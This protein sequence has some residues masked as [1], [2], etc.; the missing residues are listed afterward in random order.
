MHPPLAS[1][2]TPPPPLYIS[3]LKMVGTKK[4]T[5]SGTT[6]D[7]RSYH[8]HSVSNS[9]STDPLTSAHKLYISLSNDRVFFRSIFFGNIHGSHSFDLPGYQVGSVVVR[10]RVHSCLSRCQGG[11][12]V[13]LP[14]LG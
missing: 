13:R 12:F 11:S 3:E 5:A 10:G 2:F 4:G 1:F 7:E 6:P 9:N 8:F 14:L